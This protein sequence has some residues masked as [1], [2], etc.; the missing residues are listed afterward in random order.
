MFPAFL[1]KKKKMKILNFLWVLK[2]ILFA[3]G[4]LV[5]FTG[6][7]RTINLLP[8]LN[9][10]SE[11][12]VDIIQTRLETDSNVDALS[13]LPFPVIRSLYVYHERS[14]GALQCNG[15]EQAKYTFKTENNSVLRVL[16]LSSMLCYVK[17]YLDPPACK[18]W[19]MPYIDFVQMGNEGNDMSFAVAPRSL[20]DAFIH[21]DNDLGAYTLTTLWYFIKVGLVERNSAASDSSNILL[22]LKFRGL[23]KQ[24][25]N[26]V[27][28]ELTYRQEEHTNIFNCKQGYL[29]SFK[30]FANDIHASTMLDGCVW[31]EPSCRL[32][33]F[34]KHAVIKLLRITLSTC[35]SLKC[36]P[37]LMD[38][39]LNDLLIVLM[40]LM[41][42][43]NSKDF[44]S[45]NLMPSLF[46]NSTYGAPHTIL[47][48]GALTPRVTITA[49]LKWD[50]RF[51][52]PPP[53]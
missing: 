22:A 40:V 2:P 11:C 14:F 42:E 15:N 49:N 36:F 6:V 26:V 1:S 23:H 34:R 13:V 28:V 39:N 41:G 17:V 4:D 50:P 52:F 16:P 18:Q 46:P 12:S 25:S 27:A 9:V 19:S 10:F 30:Q 29:L 51:D 35:F 45:S 37:K 3:Y 31:G 48:L 5:P 21:R 43:P 7:Q 32:T 47:A 33:A 8:E 24:F 53:V 38:G 20:T 44:V